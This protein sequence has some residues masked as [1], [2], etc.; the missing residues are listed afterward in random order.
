MVIKIK[1]VETL[2]DLQL[3]VNFTNGFTKIYNIMPILDKNQN[4]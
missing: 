4:M 1:S 2:D 3:K